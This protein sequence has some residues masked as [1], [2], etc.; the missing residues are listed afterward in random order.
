MLRS[1]LLHLETRLRRTVFA[2]MVALLL[3]GTVRGEVGRLFLPLMPLL[4]VVATLRREGGQIRG[5]G[6]LE[7]GWLALL[8]LVADVVLRLAW[9]LP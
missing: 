7:A 1:P 4:L 8:L 9:R 5:L 6:S 2:L 3:S